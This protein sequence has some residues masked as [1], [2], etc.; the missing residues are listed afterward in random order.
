MDKKEFDEYVRTRYEYQVKW[1]D[2]QSISYKRL[3]YLFQ[4]PMI[5]LSAIIPVFAVLDIRLVTV[6]MSAI[7]AVFMGIL[8]FS[9]FEEKWQ[10]YRTTCELLRKELYY[11][12]SRIDHY[13][14]AESPEELFVER[15]ESLISIEHT[16]WAAI[17]K[18]KH[19]KN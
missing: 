11:F 6:V 13:K 5:S 14:T 7:V 4:I 8:N 9:K 19:R 15:I 12:K 2:N 16:K 17:E 18:E 10:N 1:Y 3:T